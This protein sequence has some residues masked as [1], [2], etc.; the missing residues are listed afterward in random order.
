MRADR[1]SRLRILKVVHGLPPHDQAGTEVYAK[2]LSLTLAQRH[3]IAVLYRRK[4]PTRP[5]LTLSRLRSGPL[6][7]YELVQNLDET[8]VATNCRLF[9]RLYWNQAVEMPFRTVVEDFR[10]DVVHFQHVIRLSASL[11]PLSDALGVPAVMTLHDYWLVCPRIKLL[12]VDGTLCH[13][14]RHG[15]ECLHCM[16]PYVKKDVPRGGIVAAKL[17]LIP[18]A[19]SMTSWRQGRHPSPN[20]IAS[21]FDRPRALREAFRR[22]GAAISPSRFLERMLARSG[23]QTGVIRIIP[24]GFDRSPYT[25]VGRQ[26]APTLRLG[27]LGG[28]SD[29]KGLHVLLKA[30][31]LAPDLRLEVLVFAHLDGGHPYQAELARL[32]A[33][34]PVRFV[35]R[36]DHARIADVLASV[37]IVVVPSLWWENDPLVVQEAYLAG[38][39]VV[40]SRLGALREKVRHGRSGLTFGAGNH[41]ELASHI[42]DLAEQPRLLEHLRM[43]LPLPPTVEENAAAVE[44]VYRD[45]LE[46][47]RSAAVSQ[48]IGSNRR[49]LRPSP[50][51]TTGGC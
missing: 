43:N 24:H 45:V 1:P 25:A 8:D 21:L 28:L 30:L 41:V 3:E 5:S 14:P 2:T 12:K 9:S 36:F 17:G 18:F 33:G 39:P 10:P 13:G 46:R 42:R 19:A 22:L 26:S 32:A 40:A 4:D 37:D 11:I 15:L 20:P 16:V 35:G 44:Q 47:K 48:T 29:K 7:L 34:K 6:R 38:V 31:E 51:L 49:S 27:F 50:T 23:Y